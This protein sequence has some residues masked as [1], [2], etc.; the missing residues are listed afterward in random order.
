M[1]NLK[2][3]FLWDIC[4]DMWTFYCALRR[5]SCIKW[6]KIEENM[7]FPYKVHYIGPRLTSLT[8][9]WHLAVKTMSGFYFFIFTRD[10]VPNL[11]VDCLM[12]LYKYHVFK[13]VYWYSQGDSV[14]FL[15]VNKPLIPWLFVLGNLKLLYYVFG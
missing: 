8:K 9:Y 5:F 12:R 7:L 13:T 15:F 1:S 11:Y 4:S 14:Q 3:A 6:S 10:G 2:P